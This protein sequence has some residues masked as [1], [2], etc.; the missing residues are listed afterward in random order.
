[1]SLNGQYLRPNR[2]AIIPRTLCFLLRPDEILLIQIPEGQGAW[3]GLLNGV[4]GHVEQGE[5][6][7]TAARR[8]I[9]EETG[10][11]PKNLYLCG[12]ISIDTGENPGIGLYVF[13]GQAN[14]G[15]LKPSQEGVPK[16]VP[17][18]I[19]DDKLLVDDLPLILPKAIASY[20]NKTPFSAIYT[21]NTREELQVHFA[22]P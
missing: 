22:Q 7:H 10:L 19:L 9:L 4:G 21:Y 12:V 14:G 20:K 3:G 8:E 2:Y 6:P 1:M 5:D 13:M 16:W 11:S 17:I 15:E 18:N